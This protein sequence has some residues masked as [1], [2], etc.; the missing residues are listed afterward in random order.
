[1]ILYALFVLRY[2]MCGMH[3]LAF[4]HGSC[5]MICIVP[6]TH[7]IPCVLASFNYAQC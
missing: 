4:E 2:Q 1:M 5:C 3:V 7:P 6:K